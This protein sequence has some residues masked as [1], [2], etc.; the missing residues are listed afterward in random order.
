[1][2]KV[3]KTSPRFGLRQQLCF[4]GK[5]ALLSK[6]TWMLRSNTFEQRLHFFRIVSSTCFV[7]V[8]NKYWHI[9][10]NKVFF[11]MKD[12]D[13]MLLRNLFPSR[14][15]YSLRW[16]KELMACINRNG[17][18]RKIKQAVSQVNSWIILICFLTPLPLLGLIIKNREFLTYLSP[19]ASYM[20]Y[21][22]INLLQ[23]SKTEFELFAK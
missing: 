18:F 23:F 20:P 12:V 13:F 1:M 3:C 22:D 19:A 4:M 17:V 15:G 5:R 10:F 16:W 6:G 21:Y 7:Y 2:Y 11:G 9:N 14:R 8:E